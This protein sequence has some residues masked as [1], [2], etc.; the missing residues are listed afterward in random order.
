MQPTHSYFGGKTDDMRTSIRMQLSTLFGG[1]C[2]NRCNLQAKNCIIRIAKET[3][4]CTHVGRLRTWHNYQPEKLLLCTMCRLVEDGASIQ[5][6]ANGTEF[7]K[8]IAQ[9]FRTCPLLYRS[10]S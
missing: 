9:I 5:F 6:S 1:V 4:R 2:L 10:R 8:C 3:A 7:G